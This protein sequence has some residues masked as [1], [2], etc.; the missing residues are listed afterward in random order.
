MVSSF[1]CFGCPAWPRVWFSQL[2]MVTPGCVYTEFGI[3]VWCRTCDS[4]QRR[5]SQ[6]QYMRAAA[7]ASFRGCCQPT[8]ISPNASLHPRSCLQENSGD[9]SIDRPPTHTPLLQNCPLPPSKKKGLAFHV[10]YCRLLRG[11]GSIR[12]VFTRTSHSVRV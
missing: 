3:S 9:E 8:P 1:E 2:L 12:E 7:T 5:K 6:K 10:W 4:S 11:R